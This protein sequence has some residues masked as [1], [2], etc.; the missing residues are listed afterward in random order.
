MFWL[1]VNKISLGKIKKK[2]P[3]QTE[4]FVTL[5]T[6]RGLVSLVPKCFLG[7]FFPLPLVIVPEVF[8]KV[9]WSLLSEG[10]SF[11]ALFIDHFER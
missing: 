4:Q 6:I 10:I 1:N 9:N 3:Q 5:K 11:P 2:T 7:I 8:A